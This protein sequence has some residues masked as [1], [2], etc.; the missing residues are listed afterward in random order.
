MFELLRWGRAFQPFAQPATNVSGESNKGS[1]QW[2]LWWSVRRSD[3]AD[4]CR[5]L[6]L[7]SEQSERIWPPRLCGQHLSQIIL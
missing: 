4:V 1:V 6:N 3:I 5:S 2:F 7:I